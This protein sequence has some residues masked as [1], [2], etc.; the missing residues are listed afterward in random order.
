[1]KKAIVAIL[2]ICAGSTTI[3]AQENTPRY[4]ASSQHYQV[5]SHVSQN[6]ADT[7]S[8]ALEALFR[9]YNSYFHFDPSILDTKMQVRV[10]SS[11]DAYVA[12]ASELIDPPQD[13]YV[14]L[15][16]T[17]PARSQLIGWYEDSEDN[18]T[19]FSHQAFIQFLR[20]FVPNPPLWMREGFAVYFEQSHYDIEFDSVSYKENLAWLSTLKNA[21]AA[22][23]LDVISPEQLVV[24]NTETASQQ[25]ED[26]YPRAWAM[27]SFLMHSPVREY[28]RILWD[29]ISRLEASRT[30]EENSRI[31]SEKVFRWVEPATFR[32][33]FHFYLQTRR[34]FRDLVQ[35]GVDLYAENKYGMAE[36]LF[37][38][39]LNLQDSNYIPYYYL[40]LINY[41]RGNYTLADFYFNT[42]LDLGAEKAVALYALGVNAYADSRNEEALDLLQQTLEADPENYQERVNELTQ[43]IQDEA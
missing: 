43:R 10:F 18:Q 27:I 8:D 16:Y 23:E 3:L 9:F 17:D 22:D 13:E 25:I 39:A 1:M 29:A 42:A 40:G 28:N 30:T 5:V 32:E 12:Y 33:D 31:I 15:H 41:T 14:Y 7:T 36:Q 11:N 35:E 4:T 38:R 37:V 6:H 24:M 2:L 34:T 19:A 21:L 20:A 26:F